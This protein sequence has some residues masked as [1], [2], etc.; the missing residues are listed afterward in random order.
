[1]LWSCL[2]FSKKEGYL[3]VHQYFYLFAEATAALASLFFLSGNYVRKTG[4]QTEGNWWRHFC[5]AWNFGCS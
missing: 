5:Y 3:V 1:M 2:L 4:F